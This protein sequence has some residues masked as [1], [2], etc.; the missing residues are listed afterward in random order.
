M[1]KAIDENSLPNN[2]PNSKHNQRKN[3]INP[4][5]R[6]KAVFACTKGVTINMKPK[7]VIPKIIKIDSVSNDHLTNVKIEFSKDKSLLD[8]LFS[9]K[10]SMLIKK[11]TFI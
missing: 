8:K 6:P 2:K 1:N 4:F 10:N 9:M 7:E 5:A 11:K 3:K